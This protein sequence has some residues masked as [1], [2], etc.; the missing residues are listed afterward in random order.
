MFELP[1]GSNRGATRGSGG[2]IVWAFVCVFA[3]LLA[4][5]CTTKVRTYE[6]PVI[7][8]Q[9]PVDAQA[10]WSCNRDVMRRAAKGKNFTMREF[11]GAAA[12]FD[13]LTGIPADV[14]ETNVGLL[15]GP[16]IRDDLRAWDAWHEENGER[17]YWNSEDG[18]VDLRVVEDAG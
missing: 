8:L 16:T 17:L 4:V 2:G 7:A 5:G 15:P 12:F 1:R 10:V 11:E 14:Q 13:R 18:A 3:G 9:A 6:C